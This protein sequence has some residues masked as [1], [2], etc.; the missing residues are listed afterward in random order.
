VEPVSV[1]AWATS[2][3]TSTSMVL[4]TTVISWCSFRGVRLSSCSCASFQGSSMY[5]MGSS[6]FSSSC[7]MSL[8]G[9]PSVA[10]TTAPNMW[11][12][13]FLTLIIAS[14]SCYKLGKIHRVSH[15]RHSQCPLQTT[16][17]L[18]LVYNNTAVPPLVAW[19]L[20]L[21][22]DQHTARSRK[23]YNTAGEH[24]ASM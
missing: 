5:P 19:G 9:L 21:S 13:D 14:A 3:L 17:L 8:N 24:K 11:T 18:L 16:A 1:F 15:T 12:L 23:A 7:K 4:V 6:P 10:P 22:T 20:V 2:L